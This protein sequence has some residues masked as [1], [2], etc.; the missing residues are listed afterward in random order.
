MAAMQHLTIPCAVLMTVSMWKKLG[1][2]P[3]VGHSPTPVVEPV[4]RPYPKDVR[5]KNGAHMLLRPRS[6]DHQPPPGE[7]ELH[8][9]KCDREGERRV[10]RR[11]R[12]PLADPEVA[13]PVAQLVDPRGVGVDD[14]VA[15]LGRRW[16]QTP[17]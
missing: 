16:V 14:E 10:H 4:Q 13:E 7:P 6:V 3:V 17:P 8:K 12:N 11:V 15:G 5:G 9:R 2:F 1:K